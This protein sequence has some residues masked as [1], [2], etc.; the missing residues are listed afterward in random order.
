MIKAF[1]CIDYFVADY[2]RCH[3]TWML[4][5]AIDRNS[6]QKHDH[7]KGAVVFKTHCAGCHRAD[8]QGALLGL[9]RDD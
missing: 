6:D 9:I 1:S 4:T 5:K 2:Y 3:V 8:L 7:E